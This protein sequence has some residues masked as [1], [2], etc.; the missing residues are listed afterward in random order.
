MDFFDERRERAVKDGQ[1]CVLR[2]TEIIAVEIPASEIQCHDPC[3]GLDQTAGHQEVIGISRGTVAVSFRIAL[4]IT[5]AHCRVFF[6]EVERVSQ[7]A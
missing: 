6:G 3:T 1:V 4:P 2:F 5:V 7:F